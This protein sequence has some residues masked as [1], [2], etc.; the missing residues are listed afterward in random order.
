MYLRIVDHDIQSQTLHRQSADRRQQCVRRDDAIVLRGH[1]S[2]ARIH[3]FLLGVED[4][5]RGS[6]PDPR[7]F[8]DTVERLRSKRPLPIPSQATKLPENHSHARGS[9]P[10]VE[11]V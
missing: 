11:I 3:Q 6:L 5:E 8:A 9:S 4:V 2:H 7:L 10:L 1:Q